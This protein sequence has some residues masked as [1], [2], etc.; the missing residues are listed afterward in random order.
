M[1]SETI[2]IFFQ[3]ATFLAPWFAASFILSVATTF[4]VRKFAPRFGLVD[5]PVAPKKLHDKSIPLFGGLAIY[6]SIFLVVLFLLLFSKALTSGEIG[7]YHYL[8]FF[9]GGLILMIGGFLD[10]KY[11]LP[12]K[13]AIIAPT[14]AALTAVL[15][16]IQVEK[17]TNPLGGIF[18]LTAWQSDVLVFVW[19]MVIMFTTKFLDG[20]DG[21]ATG[22][23]SIG[24]IMIMALAL[25]AAYF[26]PDVALLAVISLGALLGFLIFNFN[27]A[28]IFLGEA[29]STFVG[30]LIGTLAVISGGKLATALLVVGIPLLD[31]IF[32]VTRRAIRYGWRAAVKGD[33]TH[34][35]HRLLAVGF[36]EKKVVLLYYV[37]AGVFGTLTLFLQS[38]EKLIALGLLGLLAVVAAFALT[39]HPN[40]LPLFDSAQ[41]GLRNRRPP[42]GSLDGK[43]VKV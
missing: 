7:S 4:F 27:P 38:K 22:V 39:P 15:F 9:L 26:Q 41:S 23:S 35:H 31:V 43:N 40:P 28:S 1:I 10:D 14:L 33:R 16:G 36:S 24:A 2:N 8:G 13:F 11:T 34:L 20:L 19:L 32:V 30:F 25:T 29:G 18:Y 12:P 17:L 5:I 6:F 3:D 42:R 37:V 21:L